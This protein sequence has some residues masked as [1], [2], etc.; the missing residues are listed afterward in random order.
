M[1][2]DKEFE[3]FFRDRLDGLEETPPFNAWEKIKEDIKPPR[4]YYREMAALALL[5][6]ISTFIYLGI[7]EQTGKPEIA[8]VQQSKDQSQVAVTRKSPETSPPPRPPRS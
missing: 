5:C 7:K 2:T 6:L 3:D 1:Q 4:T 8:V